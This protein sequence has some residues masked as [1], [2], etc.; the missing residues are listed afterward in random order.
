MQSAVVRPEDV[1]IE[2]P[3]PQQTVTPS[4]LFIHI[5]EHQRILD[6]KRSTYGLFIVFALCLGVGL[7]MLFKTCR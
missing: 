1:H 4:T 5:H 6:T 2:F 3:V 7:G